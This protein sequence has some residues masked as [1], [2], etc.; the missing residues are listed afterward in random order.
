MSLD[1]DSFLL[2]LKRPKRTDG[3]TSYPCNIDESQYCGGTWQG[4]IKQ[5]DYI[6]G[7]G[8]TAVSYK[9]SVIN[10]PECIV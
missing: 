5:L 8:F 6:Q 1:Q 4:I 10:L 9:S 3:S 7:M 2:I